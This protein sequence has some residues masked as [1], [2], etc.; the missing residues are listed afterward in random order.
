MARKK[1]Q[2]E[3]MFS[4]EKLTPDELDQ[5][6]Q[7]IILHPSVGTAYFGTVTITADGA[8]AL[9]IDQERADYPRAINLS[10]LG[11]A[12]GMGGTADVNG[13]NQFG[14]A[15]TESIGFA[16]AAGGG[17]V[18]GTKVFARVTSGTVTI[19]GL[20]GTAIGSCYLG[21]NI[22]GS[23][24]FGLPARLGGTADVKRATWVDADVAKMLNIATGGTAATPGTAQSDVKIAVAGGI[25]AADSFVITYR[26]SFNA[27]DDGNIFST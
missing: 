23:P 1:S 24:A 17:T 8:G 11:V 7:Y 25:A 21:V 5:D 3:M 14:S 2:P 19:A 27:T 16:T 10:I 6:L 22:S 26:S 9:V 20:G 18:N 12:G 15:I 13:F 4:G